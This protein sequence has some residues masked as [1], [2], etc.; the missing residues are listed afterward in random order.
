MAEMKDVSW[1][2]DSSE[3]KKRVSINEDIFMNGD[4]LDVGME[5]SEDIK[6][7]CLSIGDQVLDGLKEVETKVKQYNIDLGST[8]DSER[9]KIEDILSDLVKEIDIAKD[10]ANQEYEIIRKYAAGSYDEDEIFSKYGMSL[11]DYIAA[12]TTALVGYYY[13]NTA[14]RILATAGMAGFQFGEGFTEFFEGLADGAIS[15]TAAGCAIVN[16]DKISESL[17]NAKGFEFAKNLWENNSA[18]KWL[19]RN[20]YFDDNSLYA[21]AFY[22]AGEATGAALTGKGIETYFKKAAVIKEGLEKLGDASEDFTERLKVYEEAGIDHSTALVLAA[23]AAAVTTMADGVID[24][25]V[26]A[27]V[28]GAAKDLGLKSTTEN[29]V[30]IFVDNEDSANKIG[31]KISNTAAKEVGKGVNYPIDQAQ[32]GISDKYDDFVIDNADKLKKAKEENKN[33]MDWTYS[34]VKNRI[35]NNNTNS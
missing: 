18:Y 33:M 25:K 26:S 11:K 13:P 14:Q 27:S 22:M 6:I 32:E 15:I 28:T 24:D 17:Q 9:S 30:N 20:S 12:E 23:P 21:K 1:Q 34:D 31:E 10:L 8:I 35:E 5:I 3:N 16:A 19:D 2:N 7:V 29:A 4:Q